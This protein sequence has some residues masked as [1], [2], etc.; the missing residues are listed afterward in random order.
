MP[1]VS[2]AKPNTG[3]NCFSIGRRISCPA[4]P[5][6]CANWRGGWATRKRGRGEEEKRERGEKG[7]RRRDFCAIIRKKRSQPGEFSII[8]CTKR[9]PAK[10][11]RRSQSRI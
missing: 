3:C 7:K 1:I 5:R 2:Y 10:R 9:S 4:A 11:A 6:S 8:C